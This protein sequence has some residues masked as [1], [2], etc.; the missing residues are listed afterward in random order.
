[1]LTFFLYAIVSLVETIAWAMVSAGNVEFAAFYFST[2]GYWGSI[3]GYALPWIFALLQIIL[4]MNGATGAFPG[5]WTL[6]L[7][8]VGLILWLAIGHI[9]IFL[10]PP[11]LESLGLGPANN[12]ASEFQVPGSN[13]CVCTVPNVPTPGE[14]ASVMDQAAYDVQVAQRDYACLTQCPA[15]RSECPLIRQPI[16][17]E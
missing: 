2:V 11:F 8:I 7:F 17:T 12:Q 10:V 5:T 13:N 6:V 4:T 3:V 16:Q 15:E 1:M 14:F 9:H